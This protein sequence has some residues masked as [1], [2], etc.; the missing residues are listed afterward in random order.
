[1]TR[2]GPWKMDAAM[3]IDRS[4]R[5]KRTYKTYLTINLEIHPVVEL[6]CGVVRGA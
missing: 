1:M 6:S 2:D 4:S 3:G 5:S